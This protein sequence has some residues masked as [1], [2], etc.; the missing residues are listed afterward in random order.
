MPS[1]GDVEKT[2]YDHKVHCHTLAVNDVVSPTN[3]KDP[4]AWDMAAVQGYD[5]GSHRQIT[6]SYPN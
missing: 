3:G 5:V 2:Y 6:N 4:R 1:H